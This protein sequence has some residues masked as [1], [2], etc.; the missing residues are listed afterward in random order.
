M[1]RHALS[2][3]FEPQLTASVEGHVTL[4]DSS[5]VAFEFLSSEVCSGC[6]LERMLQIKKFMTTYGIVQVK[7]GAQQGSCD[8]SVPQ[9]VC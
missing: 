3:P 5:G 9:Y 6:N 7:Q 8:T 4:K 2:F 1:M